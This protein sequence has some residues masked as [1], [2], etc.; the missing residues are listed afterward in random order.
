VDVS[1]L[2]QTSVPYFVVT[3]PKFIKLPGYT[4]PHFKS[5]WQTLFAFLFATD[6]QLLMANRAVDPDEDMFGQ[7]LDTRDLSGSQV[8]KTST[9]ILG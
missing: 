1:L 9:N 2:K 5:V 6:E 8:S 7:R 3:E 4:A